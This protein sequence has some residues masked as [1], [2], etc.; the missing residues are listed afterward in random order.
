MKCEKEARFSTG[1]CLALNDD[2]SQKLDSIGHPLGVVLPIWECTERKLVSHTEHNK[3]FQEVVRLAKS[4]PKKA[5]WV[6]SQRLEGAVHQGDNV[7]RLKG[8]GETSKK[9]LK[10]PLK[11]DSVIT[12]K[13][14]WQHFECDP[15]RRKA[16]A[17]RVDKMSLE[18]PLTLLAIAEKSDEGPP[19]DIDH[20]KHKNNNPHFSL[21]KAHWKKKVLEHPQ[22]K[23]IASVRDMVTHF[24][25]VGQE[26]CKGTIC[27]NKW[28]LHHDALSLMTSKEKIEWME[29]R[30][31]LKHWWL[32]QFNLNSHTRN[33]GQPRPVGQHAGA[34]SW[35]ATSNKDHDDIVLSH[36]AA[37]P[38]LAEDDPKKFSL[39]SPRKMSLAH[40]KI[41]NNPPM[42]RDGEV[43]CNK[44]GIPGHR[45]DHNILGT[46]QHWWQVHHN[47]GLNINLNINGHRGDANRAEKKA[48]WGGKR[49]KK[50]SQPNR[51][52][53]PDA[54]E[55]MKEF[56]TASKDKF[57]DV[58]IATKKNA[59][60]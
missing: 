51:W 29:E 53:H 45:I 28:M 16:F 26:H 9:I 4:A 39:S 50:T 60:A 21:C 19:Q 7:W 33:F 25:K 3:A 11:K 32:P 27:E 59:E 41:H 54:E 5:P 40:Q 43:I 38:L 22:M 10:Q 20:R 48:N 17:N 42:E 31:H 8:I 13:E 58:H 12:I 15:S 2:G 47:K 52:C 35:D 57:E 6:V 14:F 34:N 49:T 44:S 56:F 37:T 30:D 18:K 55:A 1:C 24:V 46:V 36:V 23:A